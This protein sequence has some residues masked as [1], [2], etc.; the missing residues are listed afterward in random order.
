MQDKEDIHSEN[1]T[2]SLIQPGVVLSDQN[3][4]PQLEGAFTVTAAH[5]HTL[6]GVIPAVWTKSD[7]S[8][9]DVALRYV[10]YYRRG[11]GQN[12]IV[13]VGLIKVCKVAEC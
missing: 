13:R 10:K 12:S 6:Q 7:G 11:A 5:S 4:S 2:A 9:M 1:A 8:K 3:S